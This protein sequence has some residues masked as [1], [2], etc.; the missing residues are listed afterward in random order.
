MKQRNMGIQDTHMGVNV[1]QNAGR[2]MGRSFFCLWIVFK[3]R[4]PNGNS[5]IET[6]LVLCSFCSSK[7]DDEQNQFLEEL[8]TGCPSLQF[9]DGAFGNQKG[10]RQ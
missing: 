3:D 8:D 6:T 10:P 4:R 1:A 2:L 9:F 5:S 7:I